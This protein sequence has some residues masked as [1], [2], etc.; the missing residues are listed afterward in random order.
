MK[1]EILLDSGWK[2]AQQTHSELL[3]CSVWLGLDQWCN[4]CVL[5]QST[6]VENIEWIMYIK[7]TFWIFFFF[8]FITEK[9]VVNRFRLQNTLQRIWGLIASPCIKCLIDQSQELYKSQP[10]PLILLLTH[11]FG[12][13]PEGGLGQNE[14]SDC[15]LG[16]FKNDLDNDCS[17]YIYCK[18]SSFFFFTI[19]WYKWICTYK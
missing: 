6:L 4:Y 3:F 13:K 8:S 17:S 14:C 10:L 1:R 9:P 7:S 11:T 16:N 19:N 15:H 2:S 5:K 18:F 12:P